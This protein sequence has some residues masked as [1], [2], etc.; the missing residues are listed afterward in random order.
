MISGIVINVA[1]VL[2]TKILTPSNFTWSNW[3]EDYEEY[4]TMPF[5]CLSLFFSG[6][7]SLSIASSYR[8][9]RKAV[10]FLF[11]F[12]T[13]AATIY[14]LYQSVQIYD[15]AFRQESSIA[16]D[17]IIQNSTNFC[18]HQSR[19]NDF[20]YYHMEVT[21]KYFNDPCSITKE[22]DSF[23]WKILRYPWGYL[24]TCDFH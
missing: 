16:N 22:I 8:E 24:T 20:S 4:F 2:A 9:T 5:A 6:L 1:S 3:K 21:R 17:R 7:L 10:L 14:F 18:L 13:M 23:F 11:S 12:F 19:L 15:E